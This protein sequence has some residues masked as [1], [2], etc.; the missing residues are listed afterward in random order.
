MSITYVIR[1]DER[2]MKL[3]QT[4]PVK[5]WVTYERKA[6]S[7]ST[8]YSLSKSDYAKLPAPNL[9]EE[10]KGIRDS[11]RKLE[12]ALDE[13]LKEF[14]E[15]SFE[16][17][18]MGFVSR[19]PDLIHR[20]AKTAVPVQLPHSFDL[21]KY[22]KKFRIL[23]EEGAKKDNLLGAYVGNII[24]LLKSKSVKTADLYQSAYYSMLSY[25]GNIRLA[26]INKQFLKEYEAWIHHSR[27]S[28]ILSVLGMISP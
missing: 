11:L 27:R 25:C 20:K 24:A 8:V 7:Y 13:Y 17:F 12:A 26:K 16:R 19:N 15:F 14:R 5:I 18:E 21:S 22:E 10:L 23:K 3:D 9:K 1:L 6:V 28:E 4:Y 2:R